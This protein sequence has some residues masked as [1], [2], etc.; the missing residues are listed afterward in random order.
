MTLLSDIPIE[1]LQKGVF[2]Y[3]RFDELGNLAET[4]RHFHQS[5]ST[6]LTDDIVLL[7]GGR[8]K[9]HIGYE[10]SPFSD[11]MYVSQREPFRFLARYASLIL[12]VEIK[13]IA[14]RWDEQQ[15]GRADCG[16]YVPCGPI[17]FRSEHPIMVLCL[18][19]SFRSAETRPVVW[20]N[21]RLNLRIFAAV[22]TFTTLCLA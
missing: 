11:R 13:F 19:V 18:R 6:H 2:P 8:C 20:S 3:L 16:Y 15:N 1:I 22:W 17:N 10:H 7:R 12:F 21:R 4:S 5:L 14:H 9:T